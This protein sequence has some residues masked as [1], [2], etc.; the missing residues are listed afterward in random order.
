MRETQ[1]VSSTLPELFSGLE[2]SPT[3]LRLK[4][5]CRFL[6]V[7]GVVFVVERT[8]VREKWAPGRCVRLQLLYLSPSRSRAETGA[9]ERGE[10]VGSREVGVRWAE[11][12]RSEVGRRWTEGWRRGGAACVRASVRPCVCLSTSLPRSLMSQQRIDAVCVPPPSPHSPAPPFSSLRH[13]ASP[14]RSKT[15][16]RGRRSFIFSLKC[17]FFP[18]PF[19]SPSS[20]T[21][22]AASASPRLTHNFNLPPISPL[23]P[24]SLSYLR[25][26]RGQ[27]EDIISLQLNFCRHAVILKVPF[28]RCVQD[29]SETF[30]FSCPHSCNQRSGPPTN[31]PAFLNTRADTHTHTLASHSS[32]V[33][34]T[35][36]HIR[37]F[38]DVFF[39]AVSSPG[40]RFSLER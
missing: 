38:A 39:L 27:I 33:L 15:P 25:L 12:N 23:L 21:A 10:E 8:K 19:S 36:R 1:R 28:C 2:A 9:L 17:V 24:R 7:F 20:T 13:S 37:T 29:G 26:Y 16:R 31:S 11:K 22:T 14:R 30:F 6:S 3:S 34:N 40:A 5:A 35:H 18:P 32:T 4:I